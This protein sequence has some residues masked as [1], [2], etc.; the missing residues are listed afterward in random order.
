MLVSANIM[1]QYK[2]FS[3]TRIQN[4]NNS[5]ITFTDRIKLCPKEHKTAGRYQF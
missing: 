3:T 4:Y 5:K 1:D 2:I